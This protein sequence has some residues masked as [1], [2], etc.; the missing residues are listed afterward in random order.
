MP[1]DITVGVLLYMSCATP[2]TCVNIPFKSIALAAFPYVSAF[3]LD[4]FIITL[5]SRMNVG[6]VFVCPAERLLVKDT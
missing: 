4:W 2:C 3:L 6:F 5:L 1:K